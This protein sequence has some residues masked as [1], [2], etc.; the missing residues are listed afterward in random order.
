MRTCVQ[1]LEVDQLVE[2]T[3]LVMEGGYFLANRTTKNILCVG[4]WWLT[5]F[6]NYFKQ[7][8]PKK[9][10]TNTIPSM[11]PFQHWRIHFI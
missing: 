4:L 6:S 3:H 7:E 5:Q 2:D 1:P 11:H 9:K 8:I 10:E